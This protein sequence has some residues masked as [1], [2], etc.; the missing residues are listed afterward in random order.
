M[1]AAE[2]GATDPAALEA[3]VRIALTGVIDPEIRKPV[4]ELDM[5]DHV[6]ALDGGRVEVGIRLTI[7]GCPASDRIERDVRQAAETVVGDGNAEVVLSVMTPEQ[8]AALTERLRGG[9]AARGNP[10]GPGSLTRVIA[11]TSGKGGVGK[12]TIT[13]NLAVALAA[14][15]LSV[16]LVDADVHGFSIPG[17]LGLVDDA[18]LAARPT[19][20]D[21]MI[22]PPV[23]H[24]VKVISIGMFVE[25]SEEGGRA[26]SVAVAWRGP[27]LHRTLSQFL[28]DVYFGDLDVLLVDLPPGTGDVAISLGQLLPNAEVLVVTTPQPAAADVA[29]RS[30]VVARQ[31]GQK[32]VGVVE[33]MAGFA[34]PGGEVLDL[35]GAG[36]GAIVAERLSEGQPVPVPLLASV[37][38]SV[39]LRRGGDEGIPVVLAEPDDPA[40][41][42]IEQIAA[43]LASVPRSLAGR[44]LDVTVR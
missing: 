8:R 27:M 29:E 34:Q 20:V 37:P 26:S 6:V 17:L 5:V 25:P 1:P 31:T 42:A 19:R 21:E 43:Q 18:G 11:V 32:L 41:R 4:T 22:L 15:G 10:F 14:R 12:S 35:F 30:G 16:G 38:L 40:A 39:A 23:S 33:N 13:A 9:R 36:G 2:P 28:T 3:A 7:V 44:R 24:G